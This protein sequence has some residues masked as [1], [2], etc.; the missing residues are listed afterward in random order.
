[1]LARVLVAAVTLLGAASVAPPPSPGGHTLTRASLPSPR[2][3]LPS[4]SGAGHVPVAKLLGQRI[5]VGLDGTTAPPSL[6]ARVRQGRIGSVILFSANVV[7]RPQLTA[8]TRSLQQA[9]RAGG[10]PP[11][12]IATDQEGGQVKRL[13]SGP[14][15]RSPPQ[16]AATGSPPIAYAEGRATGRYLKGRGINWDLAPVVDVP[17]FSGAFVWRQSRAF[18]FSA[19]TVARFAA[20]FAL[21]LQRSGTAATAKHFPGVGSAA[22]DTDNKLN[23]LHPSR[24]QL[25]AALVPYRALIARG[26]DTV[27]LST[28]AFGAYDPSRTPTALSRPTVQR[29]LRGRLHFTGVTITDDLGTPTGYD[30][31]TAGVL[32]AHA[33]ADVLL[34]TDSASGV[35]PALES[36]LHR[37]RLSLGEARAAYARIVALKRRVAGG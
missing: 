37:G 14:P 15:Y 3:S 20:P 9:A 10:N 8:L 12:L 6:L 31:V 29:L 5:M 36:A 33:G 32:A 18:S 25:T 35:L 27:M 34:Y 22:V 11:L 1:V 7:D 28:A 30:K 2:A 23:V 19:D 13:P 21:G 17:T 16:I 24:Q 26:L 4:L